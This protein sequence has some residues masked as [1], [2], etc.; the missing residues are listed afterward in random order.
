MGFHT[1]KDGD[2]ALVFSSGGQGTLVVGP[3]RVRD[4]AKADFAN[5]LTIICR[6]AFGQR[7][8]LMRVYTCRSTY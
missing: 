6:I 1:I 5:Q 2:Q 7:F 8:L 3:R 4:K